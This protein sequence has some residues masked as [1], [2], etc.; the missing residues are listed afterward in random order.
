MNQSS[1]ELHRASIVVDAVSPLLEDPGFIDWYKQGGTTIVA[2]T[3]GGWD[4][5]RA[6]MKNIGVW[7]RFLQTRDDVVMVRTSDDVLTAKR[8]GKIGVYLHLQGADPIEDDLNLIDVYKMLGVGVIQLCYNVR[9]RLGDGCEE[10]SNTGL[11]RFGRDAV[12]RLNAAKVI[13]DC[14]HTGLRTSL[15]AIDVS[16]AP[17]ILSHA[18]AYSVHAS[19]RNVTDELI[20]AIAASGGIIGA[21][22]FPAFVSSSS[23][24]RLEE[25]IAHIDHVVQLVGIDHASLGIDYYWAQ[26]GVMEDDEAMK[27]Y[28]RL[29]SAGLWSSENYPPP[30]HYYPQGIE[31]PKTFHALTDGLLR[32]GY[33]D[34]DTQKIL[35]GNWLRVMRA[36]WD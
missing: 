20:K 35:G 8:D 16:S 17:V 13:V 31:T 24:P 26:A 12:K 3:V 29:N 25:M 18:N 28:N 15:D 34:E 27:V 22:G 6:T 7:C 4:S 10:P 1:M 21:A 33:S 19:G 2:P 32:K 23:K 14:S 36:V 11:S 9:N 30:P 5:A